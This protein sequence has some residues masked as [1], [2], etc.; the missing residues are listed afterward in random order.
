MNRAIQDG[1]FNYPAMLK[2]PWLAP[3]RDDPD[4]QQVLEMAKKKHE[5]FKIEFSKR[6]G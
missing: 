4:Y 5:A 6:G 1:F 2:N 3:L